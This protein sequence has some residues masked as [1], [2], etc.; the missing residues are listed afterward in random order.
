MRENK[1]RSFGFRRFASDWLANQ[2]DDKFFF[3][4]IFIAIAIL[5]FLWM[6]STSLKGSG[7]ALFITPP[8]WIPKD[9]TLENYAR[10]WTQLPFLHFLLNS[11]MVTGIATVFNLLNAT[12]AGVVLSRF[13]FRGKRKRRVS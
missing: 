6:L 8:Q 12:L 2:Q 7:E 4:L 9:P 3:R 5:P 10:V 13:D 11:A 1:N